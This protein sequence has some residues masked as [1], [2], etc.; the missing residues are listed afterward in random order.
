MPYGIIGNSDTNKDG[1]DLLFS[2]VTVLDILDHAND[3]I[4]S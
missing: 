1:T 3:L 2:Q 4:N